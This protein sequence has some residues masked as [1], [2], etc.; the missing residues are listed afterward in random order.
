MM[1]VN[2]EI[3]HLRPCDRRCLIEMLDSGDHWRQLASILPKP[4]LEDGYLLTSKMI[5]L[6]ENHK[7]QIN[8]SPTRALLDYWGTYG[9]KRPTIKDL[10]KYLIACKL[11]QAADFVSVRLLNGGPVIREDTCDMDAIFSSKSNVNCDELNE[12][13]TTLNLE[14]ETNNLKINNHNDY[15][16]TPEKESADLQA[17]RKEINHVP[18]APD[19]TSLSLDDNSL[20]TQVKLM[21]ERDLGIKRYSFNQLASSTNNFSSKPLN[22]GGFKLGEGGYGVVYLARDTNGKQIAV[23]YVK[24]EYGKQF[25]SELDVLTRFNHKNLLCLLGIACEGINLCLVYEF[26]ANGSLADR[27]ICLQGSQPIP[28]YVRKQIAIGS[29]RGL[30]HLHANS[31]IH[32]DIKSA[33]ILLDYDWTPK[34]GDFGLTR[35][36]YSN[37]TSS[38]PTS[39]NFTS[40][41][42]GTSIYMAPESFRGQLTPKMDIYSFGIVLLELLT[43]LSPF[44]ENREGGDILSW[45]QSVMDI[46]SNDDI[47]EEMIKSFVDPKAGNWDLKFA[48]EMMKLSRQSTEYDKKDR[49]NIDD[50]VK[51]L[52]KFL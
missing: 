7:N 51:C 11:Y 42:I 16:S 21:L 47:T 27:I 43:G 17:D 24:D 20:N 44:D 25:I 14:A 34:I 40:T 45:S 13:V 46:D 2:T 52:E 12:R 36:N 1:N 19:V 31:C 18:N 23:K 37:K 49:P 29:A 39:V 50:I 8:G 5:Q 9:R 22:E 41:I 26:M 35:I 15:Q 28:W 4:D 48:V 33:N 38:S 32:R 6:L 30:S 10:L 3:R